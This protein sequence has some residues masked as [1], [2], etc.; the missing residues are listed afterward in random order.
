MLERIAK[1]TQMVA[2]QNNSRRDVWL[3]ICLYN[4]KIANRG[5]LR[6]IVR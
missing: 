6:M 1:S 2:K 3:N 5:S 4:E